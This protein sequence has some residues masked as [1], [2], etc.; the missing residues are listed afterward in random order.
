VAT[1]NDTEVARRW[2]M[3]CPHRKDDAGRSLPPT[4]AELNTI[5]NCP[6][7]LQQIRKR[8]ADI[9]WWMRLM[10]QKIATRS[11]QEDQASGRFFEER[12]RAIRLIDEASVLACSAYV[13]LNPIRASMCQTIETSEHTSVRR[14]IDALRED[15]AGQRRRDAADRPNVEPIRP[16]ID[17][18]LS[19]LSIDERSDPAG[20]HASV[21]FGADSFR[22][23]DKGYLPM[24]VLDYVELLDWTARQVA[25]EKSGKTPSHVP[26][27]IKRLMNSGEAWCELVGSFGRLFHHVAGSPET[28]DGLR[29]HRTGS[30]F[31]V[32]QRVR[33]LMP[34]CD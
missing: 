19:P 5:R 32:H 12:Y 16:R 4:E 34:S 11:N 18:F 10:C 6:L 9:S 22:C 15:H 28:I 13:D 7:R 3:I 26:P 14:R 27:V 24:S 31:R 29:S 21:G 33:E 17:A 30:R 1:W 2:L 25:A 23:S 8:L 20:P